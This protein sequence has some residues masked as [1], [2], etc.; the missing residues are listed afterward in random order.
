MVSTCAKDFSLS[1]R[2]IDTPEDFDYRSCLHFDSIELLSHWFARARKIFLF[3]FDRSI[4]KKTSIID[5]FIF[6]ELLLHWFP[7][8]RKIFLFL[9]DG[10]MHR[11]TSLMDDHCSLSLRLINVEFFLRKEGNSCFAGRDPI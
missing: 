10:L 8:A 11:K 4:H 1:V 6:I 3:P 7:R 2:Q 9:F 5:F